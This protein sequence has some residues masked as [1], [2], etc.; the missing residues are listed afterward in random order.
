MACEFLFGCHMAYFFGW[1]FLSS[2]FLP[3]SVPLLLSAPAPLSLFLF[4]L[5]LAP[6]PLSF[7]GAGESVD[8]MTVQLS[9]RA[10]LLWILAGEGCVSCLL[11]VLH[12]PLVPERHSQL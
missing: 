3:L 4:P 9:H 11:S 2:S 7:D 1:G 10:C 5:L 8:E 12:S 6:L